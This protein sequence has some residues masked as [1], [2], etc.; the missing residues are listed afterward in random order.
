MSSI[1]SRTEPVS[2]PNGAASSDDGLLQLV[3]RPRLDRDHR[4]DLL[5]QHVQRVARDAQRLDRPGPHPLGD[6]HGRLHQVARYLGNMTPRLTRADVVPGPADPL[7]PAGHRRRRLD[8]HDQ[9]DRAHVDA[10]LEAG[11]GD[12]G[13]QPA[14]LERLLDHRPLLPGHRAVVGPGDLRGRARGGTSLR[15]DLGRGLGG[16]PARARFR[17]LCA[18]LARSAASSFSRPHSRSASRREF[19]NTIVDRVLPRSGRATRLLDVR[20]RSSGAARACPRRPPRHR[21]RASCPARSCPRPG[22][23]PAARCSWRPAAARAVT[24]RLPPRNGPPRRPAAPSP[25][26]RSVVPAWRRL[27]TR[28]AAPGESARCAP[29]LLPGDRVHLVDDDRLDAAQRLPACE[30]S[31]RKSD[32]G[33]VMRMS[34]GVLI[35]FRRSSAAVSPV[36]IATLSPAR[37]PEPGRGVPYAGQR[38]AQVALDVDGQRLERGDVEHPA[39]PLGP[40]VRGG[41]AAAS[42]SIAHRN[43]A[44]VLPEPVGATTRVSSPS[45]I[46][47]HAPAWA[48]SAPRTPRQTTPA[49]PAR[50]RR[51]GRRRSP[52]T[53]LP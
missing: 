8:L 27:A 41:G 35:S 13:G 39:A 16:R 24:A 47:C 49:S 42:L 20:A 51:A 44:R 37:P 38:C 9:V 50:T 53:L 28:R 25:T 14:R 21:G 36:R 33:V 46:A 1:A 32:S 23:R 12:H 18:R 3:D 15:H 2:P 52:E 30:V 11:G 17:R 4:H 6:D 34:G 26:A 5:G 48:A 45:P 22:R 31:S 43:A 19:A 40:S 7:Q 10:E 29:R